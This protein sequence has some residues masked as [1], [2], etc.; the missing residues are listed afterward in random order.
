MVVV[1]F[2]DGAG[3]ARVVIEVGPDVSP[4]S[5]LLLPSGLA[6]T[7]PAGLIRGGETSCG[8]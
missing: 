2:L 3:W 1:G 7:N 4:D 8:T 5:N 6:A